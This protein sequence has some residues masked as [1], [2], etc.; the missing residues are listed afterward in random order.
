MASAAGSFAA[1]A[2]VVK[3]SME[4]ETTLINVYDYDPFTVDWTTFLAHFAAPTGQPPQG[5]AITREACRISWEDSG[6]SMWLHQVIVR[7]W[8][9]VNVALATPKSFQALVDTVAN[10]F[11]QDV[12]LG[13]LIEIHDP[14]SIRVIQPRIYGGVLMHYGELAM[15]CHELVIRA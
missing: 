11:C 10:V 7:G 8:M 5:W 2:A 12:D 3:T 15:E 14:A 13:G 9:G 6:H 4:A 1:V